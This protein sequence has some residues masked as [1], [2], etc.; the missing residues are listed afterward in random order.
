[1]LYL[2]CDYCD[3]FCLIKNS[4][5]PWSRVG[6]CN[7]PL[8]PIEHFPWIYHYVWIPLLVW[9]GQHP[10]LIHKCY[11]SGPWYMW[12]SLWFVHF[13][14]WQES[15]EELLKYYA[16]VGDVQNAE[17]TYQSLRRLLGKVQQK[18]TGSLET[19]RMNMQNCQLYK[20]GCQSSIY[21]E[22]EREGGREGGRERE[23]GTEG[24]K[25]RETTENGNHWKQK[26]NVSQAL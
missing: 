14:L 1:M 21:R 8:N 25:H 3:L 7:Y 22:R 16:E 26:R 19:R 23:T 15:L 11:V 2:H 6:L 17:K 24:A 12:A 13:Q 10:Y 18:R 9:D 4:H 20:V 5:M